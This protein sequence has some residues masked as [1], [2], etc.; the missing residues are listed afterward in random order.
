MNQLNQSESQK[1]VLI[2]TSNIGKFREITEVLENMTPGKKPKFILP[3]D[4][5]IT[6]SPEET[7]ETYEKNAILKAQFY[8]RQAQEK[9]GESIFVL[10]EDSGLEV[11]A[12]PGELGHKTRRWGAGEKATDAQ[13]LEYFLAVMEQKHNHRATFH[14]VAAV[15]NNKTQEIKTFQGACDGTILLKPQ[16]PL[17]KGIPIS[18][19]FLPDGM[20]K[21][22]AALNPTEKNRISHRGRAIHQAKDY[23]E[24]IL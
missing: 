23:L 21:V 17:P 5:G 22:Y 10:A 3:Q 14:C 20:D 19:C 1:I 16:T 11:E 24:A 12:L 13:W 9:T 15:Y 2:G 6:Q 4:I 7:E 18:A 8:A